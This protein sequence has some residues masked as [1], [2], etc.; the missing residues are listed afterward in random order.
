MVSTLRDGSYV[1]PSLGRIRLARWAEQYLERSDRLRPAT[2]AAYAGAL[3]RQILPTL[4]QRPLASIR[5]LDVQEWAERLRAAGY[6]SG[7]I[8]LAYR[9]LR[10]VLEAA[11]K[12]GRI[13]SNPAQN[14][15]LKTSDRDSHQMRILEPPEIEILAD[16]V[17]SIEPRFRALIPFLAYTG[18]RIGEASALRTTNLNLAEREI[19]VTEGLSEGQVGPTKTGRRRVVSVPK[20]VVSELEH[21]LERFPPGRSRIVFASPQGGYLNRHNFYNRVW[22]PALRVAGLKGLRVHD[23]RHTAVSL[24]IRAGAGPR[25]AMDF[26]GHSSIAVTMNVYGHLFPGQG[27]AL[28]DRLDDLAK[29]WRVAEQADAVRRAKKGL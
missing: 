8:H 25:E 19:V 13:G 7:T 29:T 16:A 4:G 12:D 28:A 5:P 3:R 18:L 26:A 20:L 27:L 21:H 22:Y 10:L 11:R 2:R 1:D 14:L 9:V 6:S 17:E 15:R 24:A 23:L